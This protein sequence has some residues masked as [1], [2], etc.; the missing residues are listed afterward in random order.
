M[1]NLKLT[2]LRVTSFATTK[3]E[4]VK[5]GSSHPGNTGPLCEETITIRY[6][7]CSYPCYDIP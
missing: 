7:T 3:I 2:D 4:K 1:K 5:G 6:G